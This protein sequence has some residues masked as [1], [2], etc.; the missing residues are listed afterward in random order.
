MAVP[1]VS[2]KRTKV[3]VKLPPASVTSTNQER[4]VLM[5]DN[6]PVAEPLVP[7]SLTVAFTTTAAPALVVG[8]TK[9]KGLNPAAPIGKE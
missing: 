4:L 5:A 6:K 9:A 1:G 7:A 3:P 2:V 8:L